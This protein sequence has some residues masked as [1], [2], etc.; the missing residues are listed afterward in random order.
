M[1]CLCHLLTV[2]VGQAFHVLEPTCS[3]KSGAKSQGTDDVVPPN[4][5]LEPGCWD[6]TSDVSS[7]SSVTWVH[8]FTSLERGNNGVCLVR[9]FLPEV[10]VQKQCQVTFSYYYYY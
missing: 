9:V 2:L 7:T 8:G 4:L 6:Q 3:S 5:A 1:S 10:L